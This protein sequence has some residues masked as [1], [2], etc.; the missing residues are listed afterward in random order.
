M[1]NDIYARISSGRVSLKLWFLAYI[2]NVLWV[3]IYVLLDEP[4]FSNPPW[5][6]ATGTFFAMPLA[7]VFVFYTMWEIIRRLGNAKPDER[8]GLLQW[9]GW[10]F[11]AAF[12]LVLIYVMLGAVWNI[13]EYWWLESLVFSLST[14]L[15]VPVL[16]HADGRAINAEGPTIGHTLKYV[17][18][19]YSRIF[20]AYMMA[21]LPFALAGD[22][23]QVFEVESKWATISLAFMSGTIGFLSSVL[24]IAITVTAY[25]EAEAA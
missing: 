14:V 15:V 11:L 13:S 2:A 23:L 4:A 3:S 16:V 1:L 8:G 17:L 20:G 6:H 12:P 25:R 9:I 24:C 19:N 21:L 22:G 10:T 7:I 5:L 18:K